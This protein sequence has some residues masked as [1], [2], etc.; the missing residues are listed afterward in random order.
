[1]KTHYFTKT[2]AALAIL[3]STTFSQAQ[4][5]HSIELIPIDPICELPVASAQM[6][7]VFALDVTG[8]M[9]SLINAARDKIWSIANSLRQSN[10]QISLEIGLVAY[11]DRG[12]EFVTKIIDLNHDIDQ[13]FFELN[14]LGANGGGDAPESV[15]QALFDAVNEINWDMSQSTVRTIFLVGDCPPHMDYRKDV[16]YQETCQLA[17]NKDIVINTIQ[18]GTNGQTRMIWE[19]IASLTKGEFNNTDMNVNQVAISTPFDE[20]LKRK[21]LELEKSKTFY[22]DQSVVKEQVQIKETKLEQTS[23]MTAETSA[24]RADYYNSGGYDD[25]F[26][27]KNEI[28]S[29][30][31]AGNL[32]IEKINED[33]LPEEIKVIP[34]AE[35]KEYLDTLVANRLAV[36]AEIETLIKE[37]EIYITNNNSVEVLENSLSNKIVKSVQKQAA[38]KDIKIDG[39]AKY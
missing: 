9:G 28:I 24:R 27:G 37:R 3:L 2:V 38:T 6:Q 1:M 13:V 8:S 5:S 17:A 19:E 39:K 23:V 18:M 29:D 31:A 11:R 16:P 7:V 35:R 10:S 26:Y 33:D 34:I 25:S 32:D 4:L 22:G 20:E 21:T 36:Q 30:F 15:N 14:S 12:D